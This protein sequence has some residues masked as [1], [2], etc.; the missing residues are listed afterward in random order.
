ML[1]ENY[2]FRPGNGASQKP[3]K[4][5][6]GCASIA[7]GFWPGS[8]VDHFSGESLPWLKKGRVAE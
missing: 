4:I 8:P 7:E 1:A 5:N 2:S 3:F 6:N